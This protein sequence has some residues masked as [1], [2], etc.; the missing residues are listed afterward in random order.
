M[1]LFCC[2][3]V[4]IVGIL[5]TQNGIAQSFTQAFLDSARTG[6][7]FSLDDF[8]K[9]KAET[10]LRFSLD[11]V[12]RV[13]SR[14]K[15]GYK[16]KLLIE[17]KD[18]NAHDVSVFKLNG[19]A[20]FKHR[21]DYLPIQILKERLSIIA[22]EKVSSNN[23]LVNDYSNVIYYID[24][25]TGRTFDQGSYSLLMLNRD[26]IESMKKS[27]SEKED[28]I[29]AALTADTVIL[30][31]N[32]EMFWKNGKLKSKGK[33]VRK[34]FRSVGY[35]WIE[36]DVD[37]TS[38]YSKN[39]DLK[40]SLI[41]DYSGTLLEEYHTFVNKGSLDFMLLNLKPEEPIYILSKKGLKINFSEHLIKIC[42]WNG[43]DKRITHYRNE[44]KHGLEQKF[45]V[46]GILKK[47]IWYDDG[48]VINKKKY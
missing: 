47:E 15:K 21:G 43:C 7:Y 25:K 42:R 9:N 3:L 31:R 37:T 35:E 22:R 12:R 19:K 48:K 23:S 44:K 34:A 10:E 4:C 18:V 26:R 41:F 11:S 33:I 14:A 6:L 24:P 28:G 17:S 13:N 8:I 46:N 27:I 39:G 30:E 16:L 1:R 45:N 38:N 36:I 20:Y 32:I 40:D 29:R 2:T 5:L